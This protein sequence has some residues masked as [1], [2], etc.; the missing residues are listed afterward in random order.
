MNW[1]SCVISVC[2][3]AVVAA[4]L[5]SVGKIK[6]AE[7]LLYARYRNYGTNDTYQCQSAKII[8][9][10]RDHLNVT[11]RVQLPGETKLTCYNVRVNLS[12]T[13]NNTSNRNVL[14]FELPPDCQ[15]QKHQLSFE[16]INGSC[17][18]FKEMC[19]ANNEGQNKCHLV[20]TSS[21]SSE[22]VPQDC[23]EHYEENCG[24]K[25]VGSYMCNC[26]FLEDE[27]N[28]CGPKPTTPPP[29]PPPVTVPFPDWC[30]NRQT[31]QSP[32]STDKHFPTENYYARPSQ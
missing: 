3:W 15:V 9:W 1:C 8:H 29:T 17:W 11:F 32:S 16:G 5:V 12:S 26:S 24:N 18:V 25:I 27:E 7:E 23:L 21:T 2:F 19:D 28:S 14:V 22:P 4:K 10:H 6:K 20:T 30:P 13:Y 31:T